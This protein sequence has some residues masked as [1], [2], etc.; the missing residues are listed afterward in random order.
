MVE[1]TKYHINAKLNLNNIENKPSAYSS[2][3]ITMDL[4][5][6]RER[7]LTTYNS[8]SHKTFGDVSENEMSTQD[9]NRRYKEIKGEVYDVYEK[10]GKIASQRVVAKDCEEGKEV[11][12][13]STER[14]EKM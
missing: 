8:P 2:R 11:E 3:S 5:P 13:L 10:A 14:T 1:E 6:E 7:Y 9:L 4:N 12:R